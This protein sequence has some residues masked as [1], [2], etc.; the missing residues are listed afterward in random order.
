V[1]GRTFLLL[2]DLDLSASKEEK[3]RTFLRLAKGDLSEPELVAWIRRRLG[4]I[5]EVAGAR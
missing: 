2:N 3:Y 4:S 1:G 5:D